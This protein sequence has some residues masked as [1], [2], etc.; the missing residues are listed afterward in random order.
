MVNIEEDLKSQRVLFCEAT[1]TFIKDFFE[2][3]LVDL[4]DKQYQI[5]LTET[6]FRTF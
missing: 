6:D 3:Q 4:K 5:V 2:T 1:D